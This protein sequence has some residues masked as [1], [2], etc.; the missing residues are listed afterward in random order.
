MAKSKNKARRRSRSNILGK[1][2]KAITIENMDILLR[3]GEQYNTNYDFE[4]SQWFW[5]KL[6]Q[7]E[8]PSTIE[9]F[10]SKYPQGSREFQLFERFTSK[11]ELAGLLIEYGFLSE[12]LYYDRY[13]GLQ[14]E[15]ERAKP[16][17]YGIRK[18]WNDPRFRENFELLAK[19]G[20]EWLE[21]HPPRVDVE[22]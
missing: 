6:H 1:R 16:I 2:R 14:A 13:G 8:I 11:F 22:E 19:R 5:S 9:E 12:D 20:Y 21:K 4:A 15:W 7:N 3:L 18:E 10:E 17:I